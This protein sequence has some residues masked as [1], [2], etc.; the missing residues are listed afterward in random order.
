MDLVKTKW[1]KV[2]SFGSLI[3]IAGL[4]AIGSLADYFFPSNGSAESF[5]SSPFMLILW[6]IAAIFS[7][8]L[9]WHQRHKSNISGNAL[10]IALIIILLGSFVSHIKGKEGTLDLSTYTQPTNGFFFPNGTIGNLPFSIQLLDS[11]IT[12][13]ESNTPTDFVCQLAV[14][15]SD[16][17]QKM[18]EISVNKIFKYKHWRFCLQDVSPHYCS[19]CVN[20]DPFGIGITYLGYSLLF[21][22]VILRI[23]KHKKLLKALI[24]PFLFTAVGIGSGIA[25]TLLQIDITPVYVLLDHPYILLAAGGGILFFISYFSFLG[26][27]AQITKRVHI[28][29]QISL[30]AI[31]IWCLAILVLRGSIIQQFPFS[32]ETDITLLLAFFGCMGGLHFYRRPFLCILF[33][34][35]YTLTLFAAAPN[36]S[37]PFPQPMPPILRSPLLIFHVT[38]IIAAY[39]LL[40]TT[41][42]LSATALLGHFSEG[43]KLFHLTKTLLAPAILLL[44]AGIFIGAIWGNI[45]WGS[46]WS[47]DP[48]ETWALITLLVY[49]PLLHHRLL[50]IFTNRIVFFT[51][52]IF[53]FI[54]I[55]MC[56]YGVNHL[57]GG[58][59]SYA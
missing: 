43:K 5:Y 54:A 15:E 37:L 49:T 31:A 32:G 40:L 55:I 19:L 30:Y 26:N 35:L 42:L 44:M 3:L 4:L 56:Y 13:E 57:L 20:H 21:I 10:H 1:L 16:G 46:Y 36:G 51:Y 28:A 41:V 18:G 11:K 12:Q 58:M 34:V 22:G 48:K 23:S 38:S 50:G 14:Y 59:H 29:L 8:L 7:S 39:G 17:S 6:G 25:F 53:A 9:F 52:N 24:R 2:I 47:W 27:Q 45:A 33:I